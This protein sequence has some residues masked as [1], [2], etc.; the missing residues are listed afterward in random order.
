ML[1]L[2]RKRIASL[3]GGLLLSDVAKAEIAAFA[4]SDK[5][6]PPPKDAILFLGSSSIRLWQSLAHDFPEHKVINRGFGGSHLA[7]CALLADRIV[8]PYR[9]K[10]V[11]L[12]AGDNDIAEGRTPEEVFADFKTFVKKVHLALP[13]TP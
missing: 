1:E 2:P 12:Y 13:K 11:L 3:G 9:P 5:S 4:T 10:M 6:N 8:I 7:D